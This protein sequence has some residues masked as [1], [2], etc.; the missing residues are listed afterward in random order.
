M[1]DLGEDTI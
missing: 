1:D